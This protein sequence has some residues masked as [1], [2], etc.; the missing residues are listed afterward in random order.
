MCLRI[1]DI[2]YILYI[3]VCVYI[4]LNTI[5]FYYFLEYVVLFLI[6]L[7]ITLLNINEHTSPL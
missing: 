1:D 6:L 4:Y 2:T 3:F 5:S 7:K